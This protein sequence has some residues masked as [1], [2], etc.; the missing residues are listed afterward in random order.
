M[1]AAMAS[2]EQ[3]FREVTGPRQQVA[4]AEPQPLVIETEHALKQRLIDGA[5]HWAQRGLFIEGL[6]V[7]VEQRV[8]LALAAHNLQGARVF[9][10]KQRT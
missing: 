9:I 5:Q 10:L 6:A 1:T 4:G 3:T 8:L 7:G 2:T